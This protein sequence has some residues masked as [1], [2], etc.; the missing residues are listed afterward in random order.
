M[1]GIATYATYKV[2]TGENPGIPTVPELTG[3]EQAKQAAKDVQK[4]SD[5]S[6]ALQ[7]EMYQT[8]RADFAPYREAGTNALAQMTGYQMP[9]TAIQDFQASPDYNYRLQQ[10]TNALLNAANAG[11]MRLSGRTLQALQ[12]VGQKMASQEYGT[13]YGRQIGAGQDQWNRLAQLAGLGSGA[14]QQAAQSNQALANA[15]S[16]NMMNSAQANAAASMQGYTGLNNLLNLGM[17]G[18]GMAYGGGA[19]G[20]AGGAV[21]SYYGYPVA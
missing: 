10:G 2:A 12:D 18:L 9:S 4:A 7:R 20:A 6:T 3:Q 14:T 21:P 11:G 19:G 16:N 1:S 15:V 13:W 8:S 17:T 5:A